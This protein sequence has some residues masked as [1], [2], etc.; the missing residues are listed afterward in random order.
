MIF[1]LLLS[2]QD[3]NPKFKENKHLSLDHID[4]RS[5]LMASSVRVYDSKVHIF[6]YYTALSTGKITLREIQ[7]KAMSLG[8]GNSEISGVF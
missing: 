7:T 2:S 5:L 3:G 6:N 4:M 1:K 8:T